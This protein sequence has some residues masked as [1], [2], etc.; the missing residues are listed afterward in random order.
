MKITAYWYVTS[1]SMIGAHVAEEPAAPV[2]TSLTFMP[3][4]VSAMR[5]QTSP[6]VHVRPLAERERV[7]YS[8]ETVKLEF[9]V[10]QL[11]DR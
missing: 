2:F 5:T 11:L 1:C 3:F 6:A 7:S 4:I 8:R 9:C 10:L